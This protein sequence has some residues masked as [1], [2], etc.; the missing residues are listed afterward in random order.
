MTSRYRVG[1]FPADRSMHEVLLAERS[2]E[3]DRSGADQQFGVAGPLAIGVSGGCECHRRTGLR[4]DEAGERGALAVPLGL[5]HTDLLSVGGQ[6]YERPRQAGV[7]DRGGQ[8]RGPI[9]RSR[10]PRRR[11][12]DRQRVTGRHGSGRSC[13]GRWSPA[14][15]PTPGHEQDRKK[16]YEQ[17][18]KGPLDSHCSS[19]PEAPDL[20]RRRKNPD[21]ERSN[22]PSGPRDNP[23]IPRRIQRRATPADSRRIHLTSAPRPRSRAARRGGGRGSC[24]RTGCRALESGRARSRR[25]DPK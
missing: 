19:P 23:T 14:D 20:M 22:P 18:S 8:G 11:R 15:A 1:P 3:R 12:D 16:C 9:D 24:R 5:Q 4:D 10:C 6:R 21:C 2:G 25:T 7:V 17:R 13:A